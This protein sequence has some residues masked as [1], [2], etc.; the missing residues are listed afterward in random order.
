MSDGPR[1][2]GRAASS[3]RLSVSRPTADKACPIAL[4]TPTLAPCELRNAIPRIAIAHGV[5]PDRASRPTA[6]IMPL[7]RERSH[8]WRAIGP[9]RPGASKL[10]RIDGG[11]P[12]TGEEPPPESHSL[13]ACKDPSGRLRLPLRSGPSGADRRATGLQTSQSREER[14]LATYASSGLARW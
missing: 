8:G 10:V 12:G 7:A 5:R 9:F 13:R 11:R 3:A 14:V 1:R 6:R 2:A 4:K